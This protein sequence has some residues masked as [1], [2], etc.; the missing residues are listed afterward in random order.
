MAAVAPLLMDALA[1]IEA[2]LRGSLD[3]VR[4]ALEDAEGGLDFGEGVK[5]R[6]FS[7]EAPDLGTEKGGAVTGAGPDETLLS[8]DQ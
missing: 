7:G 4:A 6:G 5:A 2:D 8:I 3:D 1:P